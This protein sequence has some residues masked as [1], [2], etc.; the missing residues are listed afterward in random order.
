MYD[1]LTSKQIEILKFIKRYIDYL[2]SLSD[3]TQFI[4][5]THRQTTMQLAEKIHGVTIGDGGISKIYSID[6]EDKN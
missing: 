6:F 5:I 3:K 4:M 2:K 1:D